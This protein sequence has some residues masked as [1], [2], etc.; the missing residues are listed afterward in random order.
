MF[1][2]SSCATLVTWFRPNNFT[3]LYE[4][5]YT[6]IDTLINIDG[7]YY[8]DSLKYKDFFLFYRDG[9]I[10]ETPVKYMDK[11]NK[12]N[13]SMY[14]VRWGVYKF[15]G[16]TIIAQ[17]IS[18]LGGTRDMEAV[19]KK[20]VIKSKTEIE[21]YS[22]SYLGSTNDDMLMKIPLYFCPY[23]N[24]LDSINWVKDHRWFWMDKKAYK[25]YKKN[26]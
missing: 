11:N 6:G 16:D 3:Y 18:N 4:S 20:Y 12:E 26:K 23:P 2:F 1:V 13:K 7:Y 5:E 17:I 8:S 9:S 10:A 21:Y 15:A 24:R 25:E 14:N 19:T 22:S